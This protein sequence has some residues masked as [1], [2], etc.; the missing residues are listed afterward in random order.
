M[1][2][3]DLNYVTTVT[4]YFSLLFICIRQLRSIYNV[5]NDKQ[6]KYK[7]RIGNRTTKK[8][9]VNSMMLCT[10]QRTQMTR[11]KF[12]EQ[13]AE[14]LIMSPCLLIKC[15]ISIFK[16]PT[17]LQ[18]RLFDQQR[19]TSRQRRPIYQVCFTCS[20]RTQRKNL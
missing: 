20:V 10:W 7:P 14:I 6:M 2:Q 12:I 3:S 17:Q 13:S 5:C 8:S 18:Q 4:T 11:M 1:R 15:L 19:P 16:I 9:R